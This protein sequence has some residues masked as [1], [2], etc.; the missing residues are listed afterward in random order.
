[1]ASVKP[2]PEGYHTITPYLS[3]PDGEA[4]I[5]FY[6]KAFGA[7]ELFRMPG[8]GGKGIGHAEIKIGD[9]HVMLADEV[10]DL[11]FRSPQTLGGS[12]VMLYLYVDDSDAW[13]DRAVK[14]GAKITR[15]LEDQF[16]GDRSGC[17]D[18]PWGHRWYLS[19]HKEDVSPEE[20]EKRAKKAQ[21]EM[22]DK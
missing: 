16:Y 10:P 2:V 17:V 4:A 14:A 15:P 22:K 6:K 5:E 8:M 18:D 11:N 19:T 7:Q 9:S 21:E 3:V 13:F 12:P 20:L 1:M